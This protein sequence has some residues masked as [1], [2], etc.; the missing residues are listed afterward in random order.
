LKSGAFVPKR[1]FCDSTAISDRLIM[2]T[3]DLT[4]RVTSCRLLFNFL[5]CVTLVNGQATK[6]KLVSDRS[7]LIKPSNGDMTIFVSNLQEDLS[8]QDRE[9]VSLNPKPKEILNEHRKFSAKSQSEKLFPKNTLA[10]VTP[11][12]PDSLFVGLNSQTHSQISLQWNSRGYDVAKMFGNKFSHVSP[13]WLQIKMNQD[14]RSTRIEGVHDIDAAWIKDVRKGNLD[15]KIVPRVIFDSWMHAELHAL[16]TNDRLP[17]QIG[18]QLTD[19]ALEHSFDG[20]VLEIWSSF[21][22]Q[23][24]IALVDILIKISAHFKKHGLQL[25]LVV[26][27]PVYQGKRTGIFVRQDL[28]RLSPYVHFFSVMT[29]DYSNAYRPGPNSPIQW[30][31]DCVEALVPDSKSANRAKLLIG[32]NFYGNNYTPNGGHAIVGHEFLDIL[33]KHK[34]KIIWDETNAEHYVEYKSQKGRNRAFFPTLMSIQ[35]RISLLKE[36]GTGISIWEIGQGL[37]YFYELF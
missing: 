3:F 8:L 28:E 30:V 4:R 27:P 23:Q 17:S 15:V 1:H 16:L 6:V 5:I 21:A 2:M 33:D 9:L 13:V 25:I 7:V 24:K 18:R 14:Q 26:P 37:D 12:R 31:Q 36:L 19:L 34:P 10:Y 20:F 35:K 29:Y 32:L 22:T 11:V